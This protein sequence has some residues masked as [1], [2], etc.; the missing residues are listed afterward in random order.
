MKSACADEKITRMF[1]RAGFLLTNKLSYAI[2]F[3]CLSIILCLKIIL[4]FMP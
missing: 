2:K 4:S 1:L 3:K